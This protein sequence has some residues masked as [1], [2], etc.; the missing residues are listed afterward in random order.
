MREV[1]DWDA[2]IG[3]GADIAV[4]EF[5]IEDGL[6]S[7]WDRDWSDRR[8]EGGGCMSK[9]EGRTEWGR[10]LWFGRYDWGFDIGR[11]WRDDGWN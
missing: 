9:R 5:M 4:S 1:V 6:E 2:G 7:S 11:R 10:S 3:M 8:N